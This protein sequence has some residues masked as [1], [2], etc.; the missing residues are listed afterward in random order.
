MATALANPAEAIR[1]GAPHVIHNDDELERYTAQLFEL[2]EIKNPSPYDLEAIELLGMLIEKY[3]SE[4]YPVPAA[5]PQEVV[6]FLLDQHG[7]Q[8]QDL[9]PEFGSAAQVSYFMKGRRKLPVDQIAK[10]SQ[11]FHVS[12]ASLIP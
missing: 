9:I 12:P 3:E 11:R 5:S 1:L 2:S 7:L 10:L 4:R 8:Q 6:R